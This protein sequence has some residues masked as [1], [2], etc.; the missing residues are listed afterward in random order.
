MMPQPV[1]T[2]SPRHLMRRA[3]WV[4]TGMV[5]FAMPLSAGELQIL[6]MRWGF[7]GR[8]VRHR[9]NVLSVLVDNPF[10]E[11]FEGD[12]ILSKRANVGQRIDAPQRE[13]V[14]VG[15]FARRWVQ[16]YPYI[17]NDWE[18]FVLAQRS[19]GARG[20]PEINVPS[21]RMGF[22]ARVLLVSDQETS[23]RKVPLK[24]FPDNLFPPFV[25]ATDGLQAVVLDHVPNWDEPRRTAFLRWLER[26]GTCYVLHGSAGEFPDFPTSLAALAGPLDETT[27]GTGRVYRLPQTRETL[28]IDELTRLFTRLPP[29]MKT[30]TDNNGLTSTTEVSWRESEAEDYQNYQVDQDYADPSDT[31]SGNSFLMKLKD[32]TRPEHNWGLLHLLFWIY[33]L[34]IF[35]GCWLIG[36][37]R[38]DYRLVYAALLGTVAVFSLLFGYVGRRGYGEATAVNSVAIVH[39]LADGVAD[40]T[41]WSNAFVTNGGDYPIRHR[42]RGTLYATGNI[43]EGVN[44]IIQNGAEASFLVDIPPFSSR[45]FMHRTELPLTLPSITIEDVRIE[46]ERLVALRVRI[47]GTLPENT[48]DFRVSYGRTFYSLVRPQPTENLWTLGGG[49]GDAVG[50]LRS[51]STGNFGYPYGWQADQRPLLDRYRDLGPGL[52]SRA[53][54]VHNLASATAVNLP[55]HIVRLTFQGSLPDELSVDGQFG[56][57]QGW[58]LFLFDLPVDAS[59]S[60]APP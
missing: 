34:L 58:G 57:Q 47:D 6:D 45:E 54:G 18:S 22:P 4:L 21:S 41:Q 10:P 15:P 17:S 13:P 14:F 59:P 35:P 24:S 55:K 38:T 19:Q 20:G 43:N 23:G 42:G 26:G 56:R 11:P 9:F 25:T 12:L 39:R 7:D 33:I 49:L 2:R 32:F 51:P 46:A 60:A 37:F 27:L 31:T 52:L 53:Y 28:S 5:S 1:G 8:I 36:R 16:F 48:Q 30:V 3:L 40:I 29:R 50:V 44:G